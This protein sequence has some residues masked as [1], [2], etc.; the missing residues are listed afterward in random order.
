[1]AAESWKRKKPE[2]QQ[3]QNLANLDNNENVR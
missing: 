1:M 3:A 2:H